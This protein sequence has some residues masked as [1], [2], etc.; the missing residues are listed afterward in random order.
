MK[1]NFK[2]D[3]V[4]EQL[5]HPILDNYYSQLKH[6]DFERVHEL[7]QQHQGI[8]VLLTH[9]KTQ[10]T[11]FID[12]KAQLDYLN[13]DLP[14]FAFEIQYYK[15]GALR[16]GWL[17][18]AQK[19]TQFYALATSIYADEVGKLTSCRLT[20]VNRHKLLRLLEK[21][22]LG[23]DQLIKKVQDNTTGKIEIEALNAKK[24]GYLFQSNH[25]AEKPLNLVLKLNWL[26]EAKIARRLR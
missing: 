18:D 12:E 10:N 2:K 23:K 20:L 8:D 25:K 15:N 17:F 16:P 4:K 21:L 19:K 26:T 9:R 14:T 3:L 11:Y 7:G 22:D 24:E 13:E 5:L 6:Y 1:S